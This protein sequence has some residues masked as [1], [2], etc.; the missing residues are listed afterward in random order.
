MS[1]V[2]REE[3]PLR[4]RDESPLVKI[5][6]ITN[7]DD[8]LHAAEFGAELLG[9]NFY[10]KSPR[11]VRP[12]EAAGM[13]RM[14]PESAAAV[15]VFVNETVENILDLI[16][17]T[18]IKVVQLHGDEDVG[19]VS[20]LRRVPGLVVI[21][22]LRIKPEDDANRIPFFGANAILLD[23]YSDGS[24]GGTGTQ[25]DWQLAYEIGLLHGPIYLAGG[26]SAKNVQEAIHKVRP[27]GVDACSRLESSPGKK[28]PKKVEAFIRNAKNT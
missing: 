5:C 2:I 3:W 1:E 4:T 27:F 28:D 8:A 26:L 6:G 12:E 25:I 23:G 9:F 22:A 21:K 20:E 13:I 15:G 14:L 24:R 17:L 18:G 7:V 11:Y 10:S 19:F 16:E